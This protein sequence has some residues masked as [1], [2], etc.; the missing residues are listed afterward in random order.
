VV[1]PGIHK[2]ADQDESS[3]WRLAAGRKI[4]VGFLTYRTCYG[5]AASGP[6]S[7]DCI[8]CHG[9][10]Q[11]LHYGNYILN[12][13]AMSEKFGASHETAKENRTQN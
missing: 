4:I 3:D 8:F 11:I 6:A 10:Y 12:S 2:W 1:Q 5:C 7:K 13:Q 9:K